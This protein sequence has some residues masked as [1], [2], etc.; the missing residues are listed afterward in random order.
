MTDALPDYG[1]G[2]KFVGPTIDGPKE[3]TLVIDTNGNVVWTQPREGFLM[4][5]RVPPE[6]REAGFVLTPEEMA[7]GREPSFLDRCPSSGGWHPM[8]ETTCEACR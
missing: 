4:G 5:Y 8:N 1:D 6:M 3:N 2:Y 7:W